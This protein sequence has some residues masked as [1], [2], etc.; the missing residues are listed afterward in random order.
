[1][2]SAPVLAA[3]RRTGDRQLTQPNGRGGIE[4]GQQVIGIQICYLLLLYPGEVTF[5]PPVA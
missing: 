3:L 4:R 5:F 1:M 2:E